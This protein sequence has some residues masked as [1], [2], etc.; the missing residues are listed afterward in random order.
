MF[1]DIYEILEE[2]NRKIREQS[3]ESGNDYTL[4]FI[5]HDK[6]EKPVMSKNGEDP[7]PFTP[8][9]KVIYALKKRAGS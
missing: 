3:H 5:P 2:L 8:V 7:S 6:T 4:L 1:H 9:N